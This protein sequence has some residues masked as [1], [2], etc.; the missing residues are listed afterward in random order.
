MALDAGLAGIVLLV[1]RILF[2]G[3][4]AFQG[5]NHFQNVDSMSGYAAAKGLPA[6]RFGVVAS[7]VLLV[8]G[9]LA[10][11]LGVFPTLAAGAVAVFLLASAVVFHDFWA[12]PE[13]Q[14]QDEMTHFM[15]NVEL[16]G[17][18]LFVL[19][20]SGEA[21]AYTVAIGL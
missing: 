2:G 6:P 4:L 12:V 13:E 7:G 10:I 3:I 1:G 16:A 8:A 15:K 11:V 5:L 18:A 9:G 20:I 17:G 21:W 14:A 19:A